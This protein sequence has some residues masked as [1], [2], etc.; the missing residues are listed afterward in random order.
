MT[1]PPPGP[2][3]DP[4][5]DDAPQTPPPP[6]DPYAAPPPPPSP[7]G[8]TAGEPGY[9]YGYGQPAYAGGGAAYGQQ[10]PG[11]G[12]ALTY[13]WEKFRANVGPILTA[14][15]VYVV[16]SVVVFGLLYAT[17]FAAARGGDAGLAGALFVG[18]IMVVAIT[19]LAFLVQAGLIRGALAITRGERPTTAHFFTTDKLAPVVGASLLVALATGIG[20]LLCYIPGIVVAY[21]TQ[22]TLYFLID[23]D[24]APMDAIKA[25]FNFVKDN[26]GNV[27]IWFIVSYLI[28]IA[29]AILCGVGLIVAIPVS[30]IGTAYT[31]KKL[32][33]QPVAA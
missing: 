5:G 28:T 12:D 10:P 31:Y 13:G 11:L 21:L 20:S 30:L 9:G 18:A 2:P 29:G 23:K 1:V 33:A 19:L 15:V 6:G 8:S 27:I 26:L 14:V 24:M 22:Y 25:S 17:I 7:A 4:S 3:G 32:T 16:G